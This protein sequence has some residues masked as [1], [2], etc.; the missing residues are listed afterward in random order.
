MCSMH[1]RE[2]IYT[3]RNSTRTN[4]I[5]CSRNSKHTVHPKKNGPQTRG[6]TKSCNSTQQQHNKYAQSGS[7]NTH[8]TAAKFIDSLVR[9][10]H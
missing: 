2:E 3:D 6:K 1:E 8:N 9:Y 5:W 7:M 4:L 10:H